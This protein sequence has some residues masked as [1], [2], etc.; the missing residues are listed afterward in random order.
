MFFSLSGNILSLE[1][2]PQGC[3]AQ[4]RPLQNYIF[5]RI[6][7]WHLCL[8]CRCCC[9][10]SEK[11]IQAVRLCW[12]L[13]CWSYLAISGQ[14]SKWKPLSQFHYCSGITPLAGAPG[15]TEVVVGRGTEFIQFCKSGNKFLTSKAMNKIMCYACLAL[16][17]LSPA[18][19][20]IYG[21]WSK[22]AGTLCLNLRYLDT[23]TFFHWYEIVY[24][25]WTSLHKSVI[26]K[27]FCWEIL[28]A[29]GQEKAP[30][31]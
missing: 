17:G 7:F 1:W 15:H 26:K 11:V 13:S 20:W 29:S 14:R 18:S 24:H 2:R 27:T 5:L 12:A 9:L 25:T 16:C 10:R 21:F 3:R 8:H 31:D 19:C 4:L 23:H 22:R 30:Y 6:F 28:E